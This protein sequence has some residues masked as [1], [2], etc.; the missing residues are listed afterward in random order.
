MEGINEWTSFTNTKKHDLFKKYVE[1]MIENNEDKHENY[2]IDELTYIKNKFILQ[3]LKNDKIKYK[4]IEKTD[5]IMK[6]NIIYQIKSIE[7]N[8]YGLIY[9]LNDKTRRSKITD[10]N[11]KYRK[12]N[13]NTKIKYNINEKSI[14]CYLDNIRINPL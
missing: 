9:I 1:Y 14:D 7:K 8:D 11:Y 4:S 5:I 10:Y 3:T 2:I 6:D 13:N 12:R